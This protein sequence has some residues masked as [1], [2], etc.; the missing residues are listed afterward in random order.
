MGYYS[1]AH[2]NVDEP[3]GHYDQGEKPDTKDYT[4]CD[5]TCKMPRIGK[6]RETESRLVAAKSWG[7]E[8]V[9][10]TAKGYKV[11]FSGE[12]KVLEV[13]R[14]VDCITLKVGKVVN[15]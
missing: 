9:G 10:V 12:E 2:C 8:G 5:S 7:S 6:S 13:D 14:G 15:F 1:A 11:A 3:R 4:V